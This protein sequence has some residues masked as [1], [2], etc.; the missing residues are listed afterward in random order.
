MESVTLKATSRQERGKGPSR[1][2]R[3][4]DKV[5]TVAYGRGSDTLMLT[6]GRPE[7]SAILL[8]E[9]GRN[10]II[11]LDVDGAE[12][13]PVMVK[14]YTVHPLSRRLLHADFIRIDKDTKVDVEVPFR[15]TGKAKGELE[16]GTVLVTVRTL[17][18]RCLPSAIPDTVT[19][20]VSEL[21]I[22]DV[23]RVN[24]LV[25]PEGAEPLLPAD[26]KLVIVQP[27]RP[28]IAWT[29]SM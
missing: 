13:F 23:V 29:A 6:V 24:E 28:E 18:F 8:S 22:N 21:D 26:R 3:A 19:H 15:V 4:A 7:L 5:P 2:L 12:H 20:D 10:S 14:D 11:E 9:R 27:P 25:V 17:S 1:R 16:G